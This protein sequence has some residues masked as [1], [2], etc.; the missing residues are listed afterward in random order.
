M[1][2]QRRRRAVQ[3]AVQHEDTYVAMKLAKGNPFF[4]TGNKERVA[5]PI[6]QRLSNWGQPEAVSIRLYCCCHAGCW[7]LIGAAWRGGLDPSLG[8]GSLIL[9]R[10][11]R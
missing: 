3:G 10:R 11:S 1:R 2:D 6:D 8:P 9:G 7:P 5:A 4:D